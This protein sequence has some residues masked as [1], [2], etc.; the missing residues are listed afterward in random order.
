MIDAWIIRT[1][2]KILSGDILIKYII[3]LS[4]R[5]FE[6][7]QRLLQLTHLNPL[8]STIKSFDIKPLSGHE[9]NLFS[10]IT[11]Q[12]PMVIANQSKY[13]PNVTIFNHQR[14]NLIVVNTF[15]LTIDMGY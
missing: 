1:F 7:I 6:S 4:M 3:L 11:I 9:E 14:E 2:V 15:L 8:P 12:V 10:R 13:D 5:L